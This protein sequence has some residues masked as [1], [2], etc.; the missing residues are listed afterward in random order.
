[1]MVDIVTITHDLPARLEQTSMIMLHVRIGNI[2]PHRPCNMSKT[3][4][5]GWTASPSQ[6]CGLQCDRVAVQRL[7]IGAPQR[8]LKV[9]RRRRRAIPL[10]STFNV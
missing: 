8:L 10:A 3:S 4:L 9:E 7:E 6:A 1:M 5:R 2:G